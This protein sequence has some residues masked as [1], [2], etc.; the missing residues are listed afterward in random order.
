MPQ[1]AIRKLRSTG[2]WGAPF[3]GRPAVR[4]RGSSIGTLTRSSD[5]LT[6]DASWG[7]STASVQASSISWVIRHRHCPYQVW[8]RSKLARDYGNRPNS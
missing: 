3:F 7:T 6:E 4:G 5:T 1:M 8:D 2:L